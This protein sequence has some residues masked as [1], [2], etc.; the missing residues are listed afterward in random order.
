M[1]LKQSPCRNSG[2][3]N[4]FTLSQISSVAQ[5]HL[6]SDGTISRGLLKKT[7]SHR[8]VHREIQYGQ[9]P[10]LDFCF[11]VSLGCAKLVIKL[12]KTDINTDNAM[13]FYQEVV[14]LLLTQWGFTGRGEPLSCCVLKY[15][16]RQ[17]K[18]GNLEFVDQGEKQE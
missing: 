3:W 7:T 15:L 17:E 6:P 13:I 14:K 2:C 12:T 10:N 18:V 5:A 1:K 16:L 11:H 8:R 4:S 9:C